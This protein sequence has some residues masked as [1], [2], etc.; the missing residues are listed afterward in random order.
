MRVRIL[1]VLTVLTFTAYADPPRATMAPHPHAGGTVNVSPDHGVAGEFGTWT[2]TYT[3]GEKGIAAQ[4]G[5]RVQLPDAWHAGPRNSANAL[6]SKAPGDDH[7]VSAHCSN[8]DVTV[9]CLV[10]AE[11]SAPWVK[12]AK[13]SLDGRNERYVFVTRAWVESG[14]LREGDTISIVYGDT[15]EGSRGYRAAAIN[16]ADLPILCA[17]DADGDGAFQLHPDRP[18]ITAR[19]GKPVYLS[20]HAPSEVRAGEPVTIR[21]TLEDKEFNPATGPVTLELAVKTGDAKVPETITIPADK[22]YTQFDIAPATAEIL[23]I[24]A[25]AEDSDLHAVSNP[26]RFVDPDE[27]IRTYWG[28]LHS[29]SDFSWDGVGQ[30][31]F[32]YARDTAVLDFYAMTDHALSRVGG[33]SKGL[34]DETWPAYT[35]KTDAHHEP[36]RFVTLHAYECSFG[37]PYGHHIVYFRDAPGPL[38]APEVGLPKLWEA[39]DT[40]NALTVPHHTG[41]FPAGVDFTIHDER[42]RRNFEIYS[43]HGLSEVFNPDHPLAFEQSE[44][45]APAKSLDWPSHAQDAWRMGLQLST[46][47]ASDD[48]RSH[49]GLPHYGLTAVRS[50][51]L[52]R[53]GIFQALYDRN[54]Y[55]TTGQK[56]LLSFSV[57]GTAMGGTAEP[58]APASCRIIAHGTNMIGEIELLR[59][60]PGE[61]TFTVIKRWTPDTLD[62]TCEHQDSETAPGAIYYTRLRQTAEVRGRIAMAWSTPVWVDA[63]E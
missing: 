12:H 43:G 42:F 33:L 2:F 61:E 54:T 8:P 38:F 37:K 11:R 47:A 16:A 35:A 45:T 55:G 31:N 56:I 14:A 53:D 62:V 24:A 28:D 30:E 49:P 26:T 21:A 41:K 13:P 51:A 63:N 36:G 4:G 39:L 40:G 19:S 1:A 44:F 25:H 5:I 10:E 27:T 29:H 15:S 52:T 22:T 3:A 46:I 20:L 34:N 23:R 17:V 48:H 57:N 58:K 60:I 7:Y 59:L 18:R 50:K 6:Q 9:G 32:S